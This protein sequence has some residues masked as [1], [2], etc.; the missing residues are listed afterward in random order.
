[1]VERFPCAIQNTDGDIIDVI[2]I[3]EKGYTKSLESGVLWALHGET[4]KLLPYGE[5]VE[6]V[7]IIKTSR[8]CR[9]V[10]ETAGTAPGGAPDGT[11]DTDGADDEAG[12]RAPREDILSRLSELIHRRKQE[13][14]E[15]SY[16]THLFKSGPE[17]IRKKTGEEAVE[18]IL[19]AGREEIVYESADL[20]YH[21]MVLLEASDITFSEVLRELEER[22]SGEV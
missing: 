7:E 3:D 19:A 20:L 11:S 4:G 9:A 13:M 18:V 2:L 16:T 21:L 12:S 15:G 1:M 22:F 10:V 17:K 5:A 6:L 8:W 14:P